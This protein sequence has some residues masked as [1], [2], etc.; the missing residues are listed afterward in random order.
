MNTLD[1]RIA[2]IP[3]HA[4]LSSHTVARQLG[5]SELEIT[6]ARA[7][8]WAVLL[9]LEPI[10]IMEQLPTLKVVIAA[11]HNDTVLHLRAG[12]YTNMS[13]KE[14]I[15]LSLG[16]G[17]DEI[18]LRMFYSQWAIAIAVTPGPDGLPAGPLAAA[19][20]GRPGHPHPA[21]QPGKHS[22]HFFDSK[23]TAL[24]AVHLTHDAS[25]L[26][27]AT[28]H[29]LVEQWRLAPG[30]PALA[31][32]ACKAAL[33]S[34]SPELARNSPDEIN[35]SAFHAAWRDLTDVHHFFG[36]LKRFHLTR[37]QA[38]RLA[39]PDKVHAVE[40]TC[41][42]RLFKYAAGSDLPIMV[43][44]GNAGVM[45]IHRGSID[46][47]SFNDQM[48]AVSAPKFELRVLMDRVAQVYIVRKPTSDGIVTSMEVF[49]HED[50]NVMLV[51]GARV[52]G[53]EELPAWREALGK[54]LE[55]D[56]RNDA[57]A[58]AS[59]ASLTVAEV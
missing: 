28:F 17:L 41:L 4:D 24:H 40:P 49:D 53:Q 54:C 10:E 47:V 12:N 33:A 22:L 3:G 15:G 14:G 34:Q 32:V 9:E 7:G 50:Q 45:Q 11:S 46:T 13:H 55:E 35:V 52:P 8:D 48:L 38:L 36:L 1:Q 56:Q 18:D 23:G 31:S 44:V 42:I 5:V 59:C 37:A 58:S 21:L 20:Q 30:C 2:A 25:D 16:T 29:A 19:A 51:F 43:F 27:V 26:Q 6:V 57:T 39:E